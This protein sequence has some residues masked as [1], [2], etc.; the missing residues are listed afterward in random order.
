MVP[1]SWGGSCPY[2]PRFPLLRFYS[3]VIK[4]PQLLPLAW[5]LL[6]RIDRKRGDK[7]TV[8][9]VCCHYEITIWGASFSI[10]MNISREVK[11]NNNDDNSK[12]DDPV[13]HLCRVAF[14]LKHEIWRNLQL[15]G[16]LRLIGSFRVTSSVTLRFFRQNNL[17]WRWPKAILLNA[18]CLS[19]VT[20]G[21]LAHD[22]SS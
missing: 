11:L 10:V 16:S 18:V 3:N 12:N 5:A 6:Q 21:D 2:G 17:Y 22:R 15:Y 7:L 9:H 14:C 4:T 1:N 13:W 20:K 19:P 8:L